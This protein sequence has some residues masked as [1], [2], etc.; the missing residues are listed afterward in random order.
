[1][2]SGSDYERSLPALLRR[3]KRAVPSRFLLKSVTFSEV[4]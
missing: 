1:V 3:R 4:M 2:W